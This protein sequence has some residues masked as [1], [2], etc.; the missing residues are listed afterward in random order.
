MAVAFIPD[1]DNRPF[2]QTAAGLILLTLYISYKIANKYGALVGLSYALF[3]GSFFVEWPLPQAAYVGFGTWGGVMV[4]ASVESAVLNL[5]IMAFLLIVGT[6]DLFK[7]LLKAF[8]ILSIIDSGFVIVRGLLF[9]TYRAYFMLGNAAIDASF[10]ACFLPFLGYFSIPAL[11]AISVTKSS[12]GFGAVGVAALTYLMSEFGFKK[13]WFLILLSPLCMWGVGNFFLQEELFNSNGRFY[14]WALAFDYWKKLPHMYH[15]I[16]TGT[17]SF[18]IYGRALMQNAHTDGNGAFAW[19]HNDYLQILFENGVIGLT[20]VL[21]VLIKIL[22]RVKNYP[23]I[24]S[25]ICT[26]AFVGLTQMPMRQFL[27]QLLGVCFIA[28]YSKKL[29]HLTN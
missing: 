16:G 20:L 29:S 24:F 6:E 8:L 27:F 9:G 23:K 26:F 10:I 7:K 13:T 14:A 21:G 19:M 4:Q 28:L 22:I 18:F 25:M 2:L 3:S 17:G 5:I 15:L 1:I 12:T 11:I